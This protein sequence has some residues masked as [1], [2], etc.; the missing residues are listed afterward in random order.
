[1]A[2][3][4]PK[5]DAAAAT[6]RFRALAMPAAANPCGGRLTLLAVDLAAERLAMPQVAIRPD[7]AEQRQAT[8]T[9]GP[10]APAAAPRLDRTPR[11]AHA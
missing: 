10:A 3:L 4:S 7:P 8:R 9:G 2:T 6:D 5:P 1:M 11:E